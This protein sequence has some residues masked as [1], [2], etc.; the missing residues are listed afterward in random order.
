MI[1][2]IDSRVDNA[3]L[4]L[5]CAGS[6]GVGSQGNPSGQLLKRTIE[7]ALAEAGTSVSEVVIDFTNVQYEWGDG[8]TWAV[9]P[10]IRRGLKV[11]YVAK[12]EAKKAL[13]NLFQATGLDRLGNLTVVEAA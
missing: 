2:I 1:C 11:T 6:F 4:R 3:C 7:M 9:L 12:G 5:S 10:A 13:A 8:P